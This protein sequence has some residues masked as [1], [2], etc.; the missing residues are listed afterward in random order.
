MNSITSPRL[1]KYFDFNG[2]LQ[3]GNIVCVLLASCLYAESGGNQYVDGYTICIF[4]VFALQN[5][6]LLYWEKKRRE[7][8]LLLL[9]LTVIPFYMF[10]VA[11]L[12]YEPWSV[13]L[14]RFY[15]GPDQMNSSLLFIMFSVLSIALGIKSAKKPNKHF[16]DRSCN[17]QPKFNDAYLVLFIALSLDVM[18]L[19]KLSLFGGFNG[20]ISI[21]FGTDV[22]IIFSMVYY[23]L[24]K[25]VLNRT[26]RTIYSYSFFLF[27]ILRT[28]VGSRSAILVIVF[29][30][31]FSMLSI[32]EKVNISRRLVV[33]SVILVPIMFVVFSFSS[34]WRPFRN[35]KLAGEDV[36]T[37]SRFIMDYAQSFSQNIDE[38]AIKLILRPA[39][40]RAGYLDMA[41][42]II[43]NKEAYSKLINPVYYMESVVD[44]LL[45]PGFDI[46]DVPKIS[47]GLKGVYFESD[48]IKRS[49]VN[50]DYQSDMLT[51]FGEYYVLFKGYFAIP[52]FFVSGFLF[53]W[54]FCSIRADNMF[55]LVTYR[56]FVL[57]LYIAWLWSFG[58]DW[59]LVEASFLLISILL[60]SWIVTRRTVKNS[61]RYCRPVD[62]AIKRSYVASL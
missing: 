2:L 49:Q 3:A 14:P 45:T 10:R 21:I 53:N 26:Q 32:Y 35:A 50:E 1:P 24:Y 39:F 57:K 61:I 56:C 9:M 42:D 47:N 4:M 43:A 16:K 20:F 8:L 37:S 19:F 48:Q 30:V 5:F 40:D 55:L 54:L 12:L 62:I 59:Q 46:F 58:L 51:I 33:L 36:V 31:I 38:N 6:L 27:I 23:I 18:N 11:T 52:I 22:V 60:I 17:I 41:A 25:P 7:P 44:N 28:L 29:A 15:V 13:V 34:A